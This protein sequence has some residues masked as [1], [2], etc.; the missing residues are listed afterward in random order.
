MSDGVLDGKVALITG[1]ARGQGAA[2]ARLFAAAGA[3]VVIADVLDEA[4]AQT[5]T[6]TGAQYVHLD[7]TSEDEW[8]AVV[9]DVTAAHGRFDVLV[10]NAGI[11]RGATLV[12]ET[13][14]QWHEVLAVNQTGTFLGMRTAARAM[15]AAG[16][17]GSIVNISSV[18]GIAGT[19]GSTSY[20]ASKWAVRGMAKVG[21]KELGRYGIR[22][23]S[24]HPGFIQTD[25]TADFPEMHDE[26]R[27]RRTERSTPL[28]RLGVPDDI[29]NVVLFLA[30]DASSYCTG[31]EFIVDGGVQA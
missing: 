19:F 11:L 17:G 16:N 22:V 24:V 12:K 1:G 29:A 25:M 28:Q 13:L 14:E 26:D 23:N 21:A 6:E 15:I 3:K 30:S 2:E 18:A 27:R 7:V 5:A 10:N 4:G 9:D 31:Q 8:Q 20:S